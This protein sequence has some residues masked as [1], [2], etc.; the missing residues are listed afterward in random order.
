MAASL[1]LGFHARKELVGNSGRD[2]G[3]KPRGAGVNGIKAG[4]HL[5]RAQRH[6][7]AR[8]LL[9]PASEEI[10]HARHLALQC[11]Q[12]LMRRAH[13]GGVDGRRLVNALLLPHTLDLLALQLARG[14][15]GE[16]GLRLRAGALQLLR[17]AAFFALAK[18]PVDTV[19]AFMQ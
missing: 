16:E 5:A 17:Q 11:C 19:N 12:G 6:A 7:R 18:V 2:W 9:A 3:H 10:A 4:Q 13:G 14:F 15:V 1:C 8:G